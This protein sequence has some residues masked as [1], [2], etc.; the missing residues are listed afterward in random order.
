VREQIKEYKNG[1]VPQKKVALQVQQGMCH[2]VTL[3]FIL[4]SIL[5]QKKT[6][7]NSNILP[8]K[9][10]IF[11]KKTLKETQNPSRYNNSDN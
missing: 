2:I 10:I 6:Y 7:G 11:K 3:P 8:F 5:R 4:E 9:D 1:N